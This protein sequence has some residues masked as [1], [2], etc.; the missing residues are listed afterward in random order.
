MINCFT[1][2]VK[3]TFTNVEH[4]YLNIKCVKRWVNYGYGAIGFKDLEYKNKCKR[5]RVNDNAEFSNNQY[6]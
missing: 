6:G 5:S 1:H 4:L 3:V 2:R